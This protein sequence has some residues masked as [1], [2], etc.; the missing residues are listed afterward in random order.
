[1][2]NKLFVTADLEQVKNDLAVVLTYTEWGED[3]QISLKHRTG[4]INTWKDGIGSLYDKT[5]RSDTAHEKDFTEYN[6]QLPEYTLNLLKEFSQSQGFK[7]GRVRYMRQLSKRGLSVHKDTS[8]RY[9]L[10]IQTN[11]FAYF[12]FGID[13]GPVKAFCY[14]IPADGNF[15][16]AD[17][18]KQ[19][20]VYNGGW[21]DRVHLVICPA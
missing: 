7:L 12:G 1:M 16:M 4:A 13:K 5:S 8:K 14:H 3:N 17:T 2:I 19:H 9:H 15:Y 10:A 18:T 6:A 21:E 11:E 20:F